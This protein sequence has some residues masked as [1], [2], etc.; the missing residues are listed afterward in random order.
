MLLYS[1]QLQKNAIRDTQLENAHIYADTLTTFRSIYT[2]HVIGKIQQD[3]SEN[4]AL[5]LPINLTM[6]L[7]EKLSSHHSGT[8]V[9]IYSPY[10]FPWRKNDS[11]INDDFR[12]AAWDTLSK[13]P[14]KSFYAYEEINGQDFLRYAV[15][16]R[17]IADCV[18][19]HNAH[20]D[21]PKSDWKIGDVRG[22]LEVSQPINYST[23]SAN[24]DFTISI[25]F[26]GILSVLGTVAIFLLILRH[27][28]ETQVMQK[29]NEALLDALK[30]IKTL[31]GII[32]ICSYCHNIRDDDGAW[33]RL[34]SYI[35]KNSDAEFSHGI[36]PNCL[37]KVKNNLNKKE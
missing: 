13:T 33:D 34:E 6:I 7:G 5:P 26:Y 11:G 36:C 37:E 15:A 23:D 9:R 32:P 27:R 12:K 1:V 25:I 24:E 19:C 17:M 3:F 22:V 10:P 31:R 18:S 30:E 4:H 29:T 21:T 16:D 2:E 20:P 8:K 14:D 35:S 28:H